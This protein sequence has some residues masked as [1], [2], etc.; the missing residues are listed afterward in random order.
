MTNKDNTYEYELLDEYRFKRKL[1][2]LPF[3]V[4]DGIDN[5]F[6][7]TGKW[8][9]WV[10]I[11]EQKIKQRY[12]YFDDGFTYSSYWGAWFDGWVFHELNK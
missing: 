2:I 12:S 9:K 1:S 4:V 6:I 8:F 10:T 3:I 11:R 7:W 5:Q